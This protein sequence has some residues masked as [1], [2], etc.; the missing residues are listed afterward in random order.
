M[1]EECAGDILRLR[2]V[3][4]EKEGRGYLEKVEEGM[5]CS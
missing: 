5:L 3:S 1:G 4:H 2:G